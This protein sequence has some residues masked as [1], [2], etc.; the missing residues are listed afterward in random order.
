M[1]PTIHVC[2]FYDAGERPRVETASITFC[3]E[4]ETPHEAF[5]R[6]QSNVEHFRPASVVNVRYEWPLGESRTAARRVLF[7]D[8]GGDT[9]TRMW[10]VLSSAADDEWAAK[11]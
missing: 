2:G 9:G 4:G 10:H 8:D 11:P 6:V 3:P 5:V 1:R 7:D